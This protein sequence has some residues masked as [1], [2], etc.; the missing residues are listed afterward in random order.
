[1]PGLDL[2]YTALVFGRADGGGQGWWQKS[3]NVFLSLIKW[4]VWIYCACATIK[5]RLNDFIG[6][7]SSIGVEMSIC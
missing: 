1:M 5:R 6:L 7:K 2:A 4:F 3:S